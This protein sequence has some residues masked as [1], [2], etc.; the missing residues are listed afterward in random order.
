MS[1]MRTK[2]WLIGIG[3]AVAVVVVV[4]AGLGWLGLNRNVDT[5]DPK[6]AESFKQ[7][8]EH[9]CVDG[10]VKQAAA[11][12][13]TMA[14]EDKAQVTKLCECIADDTIAQANA[15]GGFNISDIAIHTEQFQQQVQ[16]SGK[17][18]AAKL[19]IQVN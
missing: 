18:C 8:F 1:S 11:Q 12:G 4:L 15:K 16:A 19:G 17:A 2:R 3:C 13:K 9:N 10:V 5:T 6:T 14:T 7:V